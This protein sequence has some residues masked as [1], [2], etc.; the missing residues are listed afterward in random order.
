MY[1][2]TEMLIHELELNLE[3]PALIFQI[4]LVESRL[5]DG[6]S[7]DP[8]R[9]AGIK[10]YLERFYPSDHE[11]CLVRTAT[12]PF[13]N[14]E[15]QWFEL[16]EIE[17]LSEVV[18]IDHTL[19]VPPAADPPVRNEALEARASSREHLDRVTDG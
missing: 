7:S 14:S 3:V 4:G 8:E 2:A 17:R 6:R 12:L 16:S 13:A 15:L 1:E 5:Y 9:F 11:L 10:R 18:D 19:F